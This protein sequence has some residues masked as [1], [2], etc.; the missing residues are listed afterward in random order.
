MLLCEN[1]PCLTTAHMIL[2]V[3][4][5]IVIIHIVIDMNITTSIVIV[6]DIIIVETH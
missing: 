3:T 4:L 1:N 6:I 2:N 5:V